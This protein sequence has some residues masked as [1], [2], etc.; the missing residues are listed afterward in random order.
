[1]S[2][3]KVQR[4]PLN[5]EVSARQGRPGGESPERAN[6][7]AEV[8]NLTVSVASEG[9]LVPAV[10]DVSFSIA[11]AQR[12]GL[13]G[14]SG[15]GKSLTGLALMRLVPYPNRQSG[16]IIV[17]GR[18]VMKLNQRELAR[19]RGN[20]V[21]MVYQNP[22]SSLNP[23]RTVGHQ[24][25][26]AIAIHNPG[27]DGRDR[28]E[29]VESLL[30]E[31]GLKMSRAYY[32]YPHE[33]S[34]GQRQRV[35]IAMAVACRPALLIADEPTSAV[36]VTTQQVIME[37]LV[38]LVEDHQM[39]MVFITHDLALAAK[40]CDEV[41][42]MYAGE[43]VE[44]AAS[45]DL[46]TSPKHPYSRALVDSVCTLDED[47]RRPLPAIRGQMPGVG[48][49][50]SGCSFHPRCSFARDICHVDEPPAIPTGP[51]G[52]FALCHFVHEIESA[53]AHGRK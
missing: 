37:L 2:E 6:A 25:D 51:A 40:Y 39:S 22:L 23:V 31:V 13:V 17:Q 42:V 43:I 21:A 41:I 3:S 52:R 8:R 35:V 16:E 38:R 11:A 36:D 12:V 26:E 44:K 46:L 34:G 28:R 32:R 18:D 48:A 1:L 29:K 45:A 49:V 53:A 10:R 15:A 27:I 7:L 9:R 5:A 24:I 30:S 50:P 47:P 20:Q 14:E 33:L 19:L 4:T